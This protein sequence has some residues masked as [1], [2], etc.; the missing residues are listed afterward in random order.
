MNDQSGID[1][2]RLAVA[3]VLGVTDP[4]TIGL[5]DDLYGHHID[6]LSFAQ[7]CDELHAW[8]GVDLFA[9]G[10]PTMPT[11]LTVRI[12]ADQI[13][14]RRGDART[15]IAG[16]RSPSV[17]QTDSQVRLMPRV[18]TSSLGLASDDLVPHSM[19]IVLGYSYDFSNQIVEVIQAGL[20]VFP[21]L[22][23]RLEGDVNPF[24][25]RVV[26][27]SKG[28]LLEQETV[29]RGGLHDMWNL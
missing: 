22:A 18:E 27:D 15:V 19:L 24:N 10:E 20:D 11:E 6:S 4:L 2:V 8:F 5:D 7:L 16:G 26:P 1:R 29:D 17:M 25:L 12:L 9:D 13:E 21:Q 23:G 3:K 14:Q 28:L